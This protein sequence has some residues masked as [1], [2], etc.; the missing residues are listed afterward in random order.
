MG[1]KAKLRAE[2]K[3]NPNRAPYSPIITIT[4]S[5]LT[6]NFLVMVDGYYCL[7]STVNWGE[8]MAIKLWLETEH[9][10]RPLKRGEDVLEW[11]NRSKRPY[12]EST[13]ELWQFDPLTNQFVKG[14]VTL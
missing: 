7:D 9:K 10:Q 4:E 6:Q 13:A 2:R 1:R 8:A 12:P 14:Q 11:V 3:R 5:T